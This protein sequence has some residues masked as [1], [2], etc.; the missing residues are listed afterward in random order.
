[1]NARRLVPSSV[2]R[3]PKRS[4][5]SSVIM[6]RS[7]EISISSS[8]CLLPV[9]DPSVVYGHR[10]ERRVRYIEEDAEFHIQEIGEAE[11]T[12]SDGEL[13]S[14]DY[15]RP[16]KNRQ[17]SLLNLFLPSSSGREQLIRNRVV[18][19]IYCTTINETHKRRFLLEVNEQ[20]CDIRPIASEGSIELRYLHSTK[21]LY[22]YLLNYGNDTLLYVKLL[23]GKNES[24][25][26]N[27]PC[28]WWKSPS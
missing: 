3:K 8:S 6:V 5:W 24:F 15:V 17:N 25:Q 1:M 11:Y 16:P 14:Q 20:P 21:N 2:W 23:R 19:A 27:M 10:V 28:P 7:V 9:L 22:D 4:N 26:S 12:P 13:T 18:R